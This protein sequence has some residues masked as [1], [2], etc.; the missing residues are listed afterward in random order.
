LYLQGEGN[1]AV[2]RHT[3]LHTFLRLSLRA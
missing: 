1:Q 3:L 2:P